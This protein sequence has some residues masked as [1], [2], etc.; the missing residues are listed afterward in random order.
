MDEDGNTTYRWERDRNDPLTIEILQWQ[1]EQNGA[2]TGFVN[3]INR[4]MQDAPSRFTLIVESGS[5]CDLEFNRL[6]AA[7]LE[8][9]VAG[10]D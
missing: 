6:Y 4:R 9:F 1:S 2:G 5:D 10:W 3:M 8:P 7:Q